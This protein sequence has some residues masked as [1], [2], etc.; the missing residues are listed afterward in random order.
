M[1]VYYNEEV[2]IDNF[3]WE[4]AFKYPIHCARLQCAMERTEDELNTM[5]VE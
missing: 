5:D 1:D 2:N 3:Q 4:C